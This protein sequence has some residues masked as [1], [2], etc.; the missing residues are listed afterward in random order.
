VSARTWTLGA[1]SLVACGGLALDASCKSYGDGGGDGGQNP[2]GPPIVFGASIGQTGGLSGQARAMHGGLMTAQIQLNALGGILNRQIELDIQDDGSD[3]TIAPMA[4][5]KLLASGAVGVLGP[6]AS[7]EVEAVYPLIKAKPV[8]EISSTATSIVLTEGY[9]AKQGWFFRTVPDDTSQGKAVALF[10]L[11]GPNGMDASTGQCKKMAIVYN[12]DA[13]GGPMD[14]IIE[15]YFE[16]HG[17]TITNSISVPANVTGS[18][19]TQ[20]TE[21]VKQ[22][23]DCMAMVVFAPVGDQ[24]VKDLEAAI[25]LDTANS[26]H[27]KRFFIIGTDGCYDPSFI[28]NGRVSPSDPMS[29]SF[30]QS[31]YGTTAD[32]NPP[33]RVQYNDFKTLYEAEV[34]YVSGMTAPDPYTSNEYDAAI[35]LAL[36]IQAAG[37]TDGP[38]VRSSMFDVSRGKHRGAT[39]YGPAQVADAI[40]AIKRGQDINYEGAAGNEDFDDFGDV[41]GDFIIWQVQGTQFATHA[42]IPA[43]EL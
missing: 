13:Y 15:P 21:I 17:G 5:K 41:K 28:T 8:V 43:T 33:S 3:P 27:W 29:M 25:S 12:D 34:G 38:A 18:Y 6:G 1:V 42:Y 10:A 30:V 40:D 35:L 2:A 11:E 7:S 32:T 36:A 20:A 9:P 16:K 31:V 37:S 26:A 24:L 22:L 39:A 19:M 4:V 14:K 23:P